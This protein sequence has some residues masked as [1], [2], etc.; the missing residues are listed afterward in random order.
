MTLQVDE[1]QSSPLE[2]YQG[3]RR[4][5]APIRVIRFAHIRK[6]NNADIINKLVT[7]ASDIQL[8][9]L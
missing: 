7:T 8:P 9:L 3:F 1:A 2:M 4:R 5:L 6:G